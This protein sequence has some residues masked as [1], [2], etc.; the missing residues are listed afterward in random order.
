MI[1]KQKAYAVII[2]TL[3]STFS[4]CFTSKMSKKKKQEKQLFKANFVAYDNRIPN[5]IELEFRLKSSG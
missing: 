1:E 2:L 4:C 3:I 5:R